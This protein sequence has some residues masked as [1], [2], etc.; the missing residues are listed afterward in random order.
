MLR[1]RSIIAGRNAPVRARLP[2]KYCAVRTAGA[3]RYWRGPGSGDWPPT[4]RKPPYRTWSRISVFFSLPSPYGR[5]HVLPRDVDRASVGPTCPAVRPASETAGR[6]G[7]ARSSRPVDEPLN[8]HSLAFSAPEKSKRGSVS[9]GTT[10]LVSTSQRKIRSRRADSVAACS[11]RPERLTS[12][13][14]SA[15]RS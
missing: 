4:G 6:R 9:H 10:S 11:A 14:R 7:R 3:T 13:W 8:Y 2:A 5:R 12:C 15:L 1:A